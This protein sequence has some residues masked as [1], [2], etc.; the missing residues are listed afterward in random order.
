MTAEVLQIDP[1]IPHFK[2]NLSLETENAMYN[3]MG[4][5]KFC[6]CLK[7]C[8]SNKRCSRISLGKLCR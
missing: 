5:A 2:T 1:R 6:R 4:D 7:D 8:L 3:E